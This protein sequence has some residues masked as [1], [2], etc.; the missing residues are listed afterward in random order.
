MLQE[1]NTK[2]KQK[3]KYLLP[4]GQMIVL[5]HPLQK[6]KVLGISVLSKRKTLKDCKSGQYFR[7]PK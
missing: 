1:T 3:L 6:G 5:L 4:I 7:K 2:Q